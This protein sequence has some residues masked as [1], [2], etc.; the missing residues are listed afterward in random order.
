[1]AA[2]DIPQ[3]RTVGVIAEELNA[4]LPRVLYILRKHGHDIRPIG[5]AGTLRLFDR[6]AVEIVRDELR[7]MDERQGVAQ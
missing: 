5:R 7:A 1:M 3:L 2:N 4:P 6:S